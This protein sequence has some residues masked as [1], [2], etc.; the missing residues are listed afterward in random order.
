M[1]SYARNSCHR[2]HSRYTLC[3]YHHNEDHAGDWRNCEECRQ[4][5]ETEMYVWYGTNE[6]NFVKLE[7]PPDYE[8]TRCT[9]CN[10]IIKLAEE[11]YSTKG[12]GSYLC[13][14]CTEKKF[15]LLRLT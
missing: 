10:R 11:S 15:R 12:G 1:F 6:F 8:P 2:N 5:F 9:Q 13:E 4:S 7:N 14:R 3:G